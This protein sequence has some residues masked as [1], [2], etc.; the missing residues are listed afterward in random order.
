MWP[1]IATATPGKPIITA[2]NDAAQ[3]AKR[4]ESEDMSTLTTHAH[5]PIV[6]CASEGSFD[7][8]F[9]QLLPDNREWR[10]VT[11]ADLVKHSAQILYRDDEGAEVLVPNTWYNQPTEAH[12][13][14]WRFYA[15]R[16]R[17]SAAKHREAAAYYRAYGDRSSL[18]EA[19]RHE[20][21]AERDDATVPKL[22]ALADWA[23]ANGKPGYYCPDPRGRVHATP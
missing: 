7:S 14:R 13:E 23:G 5:T 20:A 18:H 22:I 16:A 17:E 9:R 12:V 21:D 11:K 4:S 2:T 1:H 15:E 19:Q 8:R 3:L 6:P 10:L